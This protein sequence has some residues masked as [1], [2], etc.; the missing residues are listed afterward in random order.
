[1]CG[2]A[3]I[4]RRQPD[5]LGRR[6]LAMTEAMAHRGP[7]GRGHVA[8]RPGTRRPEPAG[9]GPPQGAAEVFLGHRRLSIIDPQGTAQPLRNENGS[10]WTVFNGE[11][12]NYKALRDVLTARGHVLRE[13]GDTEILVHLWEEHGENMPA[14]LNGMFAFAVYDADQDTLFLARDRFGEKPLY[15]WDDSHGGLA[16]ASELHALAQLPD[17]PR[18][19]LDPVAAAQY[20]ALGYVPHPRTIHE[21]ASCLP[22]GHSLTWRNGRATLRRYW[23]PEVSGEQ[24]HCDLDVLQETLDEAVRSRME[25]DVPVG[26]FLSAGL[27]SSLIAASMARLGVPKTFTIATGDW[28]GDE[29]LV[30]RRI[31]AHLGT[32]HH[33]FRVEPDFVA[34][35]ERLA[36]HYGQPFADYSAVPTYYVSRE[37][38]RHVK[39][40]L[41]GDGGDELFAGYERYANALAA[42]LCGLLPGGMRRVLAALVTGAS[43]GGGDFPSHLAEFLRSAGSVAARIDAPASLFHPYWQDACFQRP[44]VTALK[45]DAKPGPGAALYAA[46][47]G[48]DRLSRTLEADQGLYLAADILTKVDIAAMSVSLETRAPFLDHRLVEAVNRLAGTVKRRGRVGKLPLRALAARR[49]P[50]AVSTLPKRGFTLPLAAWMRQDIREWCRSAL[51]DVRDAWEPFL[52]PRGVE[53]LWTEHQAGKADHAMRLWVVIAWGLW[54]RSLPLDSPDLKQAG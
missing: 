47:T 29:S 24:S 35:A 38:R 30:A 31:A 54:W 19:R 10:I 43:F 39:V 16:F 44:F 32:Q 2:I 25:A 13:R 49:L 7:D 15:Y 5:V 1:M 4:A 14:H 53:R 27:D 52:L 20:F 46:S 34:V 36:R 37:T 45:D 22:P 48:P 3:G 23:R 28:S 21:A 18:N 11:I 6:L 12:Y 17:F 40:A 51:F 50:V 9:S 41:S 26:C 8:L 33:E 42:R